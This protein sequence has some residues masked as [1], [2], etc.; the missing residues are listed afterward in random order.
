MKCPWLLFRLYKRQQDAVTAVE[1]SLI[2][3]GI[4][5]TIMFGVFFFG[6]TVLEMF[7]WML[8]SVSDFVD[9]FMQREDS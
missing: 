1:Y 2:A 4:S 7:T 8:Q 5:L 6:E 9:R 3:S